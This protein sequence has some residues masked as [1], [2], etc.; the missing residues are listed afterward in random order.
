MSLIREIVPI[1]MV[2]TAGEWALNSVQTEGEHSSLFFWVPACLNTH[3]PV[4]GL[5]IL[6]VDTCILNSWV[7][8]NSLHKAAFLK[9]PRCRGIYKLVLGNQSDF[10]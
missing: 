9:H 8:A 3:T 5:R 10:I 2:G 1:F 6:F 7:K 4:W